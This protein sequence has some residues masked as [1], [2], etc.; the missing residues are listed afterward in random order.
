MYARLCECWGEA[1]TSAEEEGEGG[2]SNRSAA[3]VITSITQPVVMGLFKKEM[4]EA[5]DLP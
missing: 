1:G 3:T 2:K 4:S 5:C